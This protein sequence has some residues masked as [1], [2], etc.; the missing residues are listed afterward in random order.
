[1]T[2][3]T[4]LFIGIAPFVALLLWCEVRDRRRDQADGVRA[5]IHAAACRVLGGES[6]LS[7]QVAPAWGWRGG[8]VHLS[9]PS[10][11]ESLIARVSRAVVQQLPNRYELVIHRGSAPAQIRQRPGGEGKA[12][13]RILMVMTRDTRIDDTRAARHAAGMARAGGATVRMVYI[14]PLPSPRVDKH[15]RIVAD[16]D[17]EMA[18]ITTEAGERLARLAWEFDDVPV[19]GVVRFGPLGGELSIEVEVFG[20]DLVALAAPRRPGLRDRLRAWYLARV[21]LGSKVPLILLPRL[22]EGANARPRERVA[23]PALR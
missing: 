17:R 2:D 5:G 18:R 22:S 16:T 15:D 10:G 4:G 1:M 9:V 19:D 14:S 6:M 8:R 23:L 11:Y 12:A 21:S 3:L 20:A 13:K 7:I